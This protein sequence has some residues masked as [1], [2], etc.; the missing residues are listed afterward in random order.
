VFAE[1]DVVGGLL[2]ALHEHD[3]L[4][5]D[6]GG[7][8]CGHQRRRGPEPRALEARPRHQTLLRHLHRT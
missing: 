6:G 1:Q 4:V 7:A 3:D 2:G 8:V 5:P